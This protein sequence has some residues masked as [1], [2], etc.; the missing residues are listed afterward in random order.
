[1][2]KKYGVW[3]AV[4]LLLAAASMMIYLKLHP[5]VLPENLVQG[6][7]HIDGDLTNLNTKYPGRVKSMTVE[8]GAAV[9]KGMVIAVLESAEQQAQKEE[10][11]AQIVA[12]KK[13]F[14]AKKVEV[15]IS[16]K[17]IPLALKKAKEKLAADRA[18]F[19]ELLQNI[20]VQKEVYTQAK[21]DFSRSQ[22]LYKSRTIDPHS[23][24]MAKLKV[25]TEKEKLEALEQKQL[26]VQAVISISRTNV[27]EAEAS[28]KKLLALKDTLAS[29]QAEIDALRA[30]KAR[31]MAMI[32]E[33]TLR[34]PVNGYVVEKI[35]NV[36]EVVGAGMPVATLID[37]RSLYL[38]IFVDTLE[39]GKI[40]LGD[41]AEIFLDAAPDR[42]I[43]AKVTHIAQRAEF[44]PKEVSVRS[45]RIQR[46]FAVHLKPLKADPLLKLGIPAVGVISMDGK[47][48]PVSLDALP[49]L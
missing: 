23:Y 28:Q 19:Q 45:D 24:E 9:T 15:E 6:T 41:S 21:K 14:A 29:L 22:T 2:M 1:M 17:T 13:L 31:V 25:S 44:T 18:Q 4:A 43:A 49:A 32:E 34:S 40:K 27:V 42:P 30:S 47:G 7:G 33:M 48:L 35:A 37:P 16:E 11:E 36:G 38:K 26:Q 12:K 8:E 3:A 5:R 10:I 46:V 20:E 39:N